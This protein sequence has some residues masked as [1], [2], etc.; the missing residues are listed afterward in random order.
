VVAGLLLSA[1]ALAQ[2]GG[3]G[4]Q[5]PQTARAAS[6][7]DIAGY[8]TALITDD[9]QYRMITPAKGDARHIPLNNAGQ[10]VAGQW[11][12]AADEAAG[13]ACKGYG[14]PSIMRLPT[15]INVTWE[16]DEV[17]RIDTDFGMQTR[18]FNFPGANARP[19]E[20]S[21]QGFSTA[22]WEVRPGANPGGPGASLKVDTTNLRE[23]YLRKNGIPFSE[24]TFMTEYYNLITE[25]D[26]ARYL[27][28]QTYVKDPVY[29]NGHWVRTLQYRREADGSKW[30]PTP[31]T[32][33]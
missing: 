30:N 15:R 31:C 13:L 28:I 21:W 10:Q 29:L 25:D 18:L 2:R 16:N 4:G 27:V 19:G 8:W 12:P 26:G 24:E 22:A 17:L 5:P 7:M 14:A 9:W 33:Y 32:A 23:G 6:P 11:D 20:R 1:P 3:R